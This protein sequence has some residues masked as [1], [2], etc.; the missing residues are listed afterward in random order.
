MPMT[1]ALYRCTMN[2]IQKIV[3]DKKDLKLEE[4]KVIHNQDCCKFRV[5]GFSNVYFNSKS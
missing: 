5:L 1:N 4:Y 3:E 2:N